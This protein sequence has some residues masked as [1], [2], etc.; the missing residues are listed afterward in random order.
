VVKTLT[1]FGLG[2]HID[3]ASERAWFVHCRISNAAS[4]FA[5]LNAVWSAEYWGFQSVGEREGFEA[6]PAT[7]APPEHNGAA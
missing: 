4:R 2:A 7:I 6:G 5:T 1:V 3:R